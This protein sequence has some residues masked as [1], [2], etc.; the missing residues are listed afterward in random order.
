MISYLKQSRLFSQWAKSDRVKK[1]AAA[2]PSAT[3]PISIVSLKKELCYKRGKY[4]IHF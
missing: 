4:L 2:V 1:A 3:S